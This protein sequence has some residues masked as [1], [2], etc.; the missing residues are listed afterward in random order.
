MKW[1]FEKAKVIEVYDTD[2]N[3]VDY[4][5]RTIVSNYDHNFIYTKGEI[6]VCMDYDETDKACAPGIHGFPD[7]ASAWMYGGV[8][9]VNV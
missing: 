4:T 2:G 7:R 9:S 1:R 6:V 8:H 3:S 5:K